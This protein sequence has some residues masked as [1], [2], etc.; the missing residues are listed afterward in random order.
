[1]V[2]TEVRFNEWLTEGFHLFK[3]N[4]GVLVI[5]A[6]LTMLISSVTL[7]ILLG[8]MMAGFWI[9][10]LRLYDKSSPAPTGGTVFEG[11]QHFAQSF[12]FVLVWGLLM[13][14]AV[15]ILSLIPIIGQLAV[16]ALSF[17]LGAILMFALFLI[18]DQK[19]PFWPASMKSI[20][21]VKQN[22]W[23]FVGYSALASVIGQAGSIL[24]GIGVIF[25][26]PIMGC[27]LTVAY[28]NVFSEGGAAQA[29][30]A[31][32]AD[33]PPYTPPAEE[34]RTEEPQ[35]PEPPRT[36]EPGDDNNE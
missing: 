12:L 36:D 33:T 15:L 27:M 30:P 6:L 16:I 13:L 21:V 8:P 26:M 3:E 18:V 34:P 5:A 28:R 17:L 23:P 24:C 4:F 31:G 29:A 35:P 32:P 11:F 7:G 19:M 14:V 25:T 1:M 20:E 10:C 2:Q 22:F 9:V